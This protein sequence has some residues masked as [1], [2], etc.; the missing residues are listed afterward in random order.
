MTYPR[1]ESLEDML[2]LREVAPGLWVGGV[3]A[4]WLLEGGKRE[5]L[6]P[7]WTLILD[8]ASW[9]DATAGVG[10]RHP[11]P[12][13]RYL[14]D[15]PEVWA[16]DL[17]DGEPIPRGTLDKLL[18]IYD[19]HCR[20]L[21]GEARVSCVLVCCLA[22]A[23]RSA[24]VAYGLLRLRCGLHH[25]EALRRIRSRWHQSAATDPRWPNPVTL[26]SVVEWVSGAANP[27][28]GGEP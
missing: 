26:A 9:M 6:D 23:S 25:E 27:T 4:P 12:E 24:S 28:P 2:N 15:D 10:P 22:G 1:W 18:E 21:D 19:G 3:D 14:R 13:V 7:R 17:E 8:V 5:R 16:C 20:R 11:W